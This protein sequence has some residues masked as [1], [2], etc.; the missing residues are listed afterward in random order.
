[1]EVGLNTEEICI[2]HLEVIGKTVQKNGTVRM[3]HCICGL[4]GQLVQSL[5]QPPLHQRKNNSPRKH[6]KRPL[7]LQKIQNQK[8]HQRVHL[9][10]RR[11][12][13]A[14]NESVV[15]VEEIVSDGWSLAVGLLVGDE[16]DH[17]EIPVAVKAQVTI[18]RLHQV[19]AVVR[20]PLK[21]VE[22][23]KSPRQKY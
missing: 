20:Q 17:D 19:A 8:V 1:V 10:R 5:L 23:P 2:W 7:H 16:G 14:E 3:P 22:M 21:K 15:E 4:F 9:P 11:G 13:A 18:H 6:Q 12:V